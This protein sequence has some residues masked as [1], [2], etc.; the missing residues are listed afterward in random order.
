MSKTSFN[1]STFVVMSAF[2]GIAM[3]DDVDRTLDAD[4][5][6]TVIINNTS[7]MVDVRGWS[8]DEVRVEGDLGGGVD[9]LHF[10]RNG[11][12]IT[13]MVKTP[14]SHHRS[15]SSDLEISVPE[16]SSIEVVTVSADIEVHDVK[17]IQRLQSVSGDVESEAYGAD[18]QIGTVS[19][20][21]GLEGDDEDCVVELN[22]VSG[23]ID[24][25][26][27]S[28]EVKANSVSGDVVLIESS[29]RRARMQTTNGD[30][31]FNAELQEKG[32]LDVETINGEVDITLQG[33]VD[34]RFDIETFNGDIDNCFGPEPV[35]TSKYTPGSELRFTEGEGSGRVTINTLNGDLRLCK[36]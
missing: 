17:G 1:V 3:A 16:Q 34:A 22:T 8:R 18:V 13:I 26:N 28:G 20:D 4:A 32:R 36:D 35:R 19:G 24:A 5:N 7:G 9:E 6:G 14:R 21:V 33:R 12:T 27:L 25:Q 31:V 15:I 23:D 2:A 11:G 10:E 30:I 29:F